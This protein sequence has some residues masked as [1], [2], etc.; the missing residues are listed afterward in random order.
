[1]ARRRYGCDVYDADLQYR[2][3]VRGRKI[4][5]EVGAIPFADRSLTCVVSFCAFNCFEGEADCA[6]LREAS[7]L[8]KPG[9]RLVIVPL[10]VADAYVNLYDPDIVTD[11][12]RLD[13]RAAHHAWHGWGTNF[14][15]W[16][17]RQAFRERFLD[18]AQGLTVR[19]VEVALN[20]QEDVGVRGFHAAV[21]RKPLT[22]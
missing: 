19:V 11:P 13:D 16:Y 2:P 6:F 14:G 18:A 12:D 22:S 4:G 15:R 5:C 17:D 9:G 21:C 3:G 10:C 8:L 7:R 1:L 20:P